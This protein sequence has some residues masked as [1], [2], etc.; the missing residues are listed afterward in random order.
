MKN[1]LAELR[2]IPG[3]PF[4]KRYLGGHITLGP[5][6]IYGLNAMHVALNLET[7]WGWICFHPTWRVFGKWWPWYFYISSDATPYR[8]RFGCG[9]G[10]GQ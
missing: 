5:L 4:W 8:A 9:P 1:Q 10:F 2:N 3:V 7:R 6:T